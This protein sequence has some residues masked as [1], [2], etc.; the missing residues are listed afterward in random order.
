MGTGGG[1]A[2]GGELD[3]PAPG[4]A[5]ST[6]ARTTTLGGRNFMAKRQFHFYLDAREWRT[7]EAISQQQECS[8]AEAIRRCIRSVELGSLVAA[9]S[10]QSPKAAGNAT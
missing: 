3:S 2:V 5:R 8:V 10:T 7:V 6:R 9:A 1:A 4:S